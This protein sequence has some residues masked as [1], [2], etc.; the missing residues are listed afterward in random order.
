MHRNVVALGEYIKKSGVPESINTSRDNLE[1]ACNTVD[2]CIKIIEEQVDRYILEK[3]RQIP[4]FIAESLFKKAPDLEANFHRLILSECETFR[5]QQRILNTLNQEFFQNSR[6]LAL[7]PQTVEINVSSIDKIFAQAGQVIKAS[8]VASVI[9]RW[10]SEKIV[11]LAAEGFFC[12]EIIERLIG[13]LVQNSI[14][15][16]QQAEE[17]FFTQRLKYSVQGLLNSI[18]RQLKET[19]S[20]KVA[21]TVYHF[22]EDDIQAGKNGDGRLPA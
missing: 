10:G 6:Q 5:L 13:N 14:K 22:F 1:K 9:G 7:K 15:E 8:R 11:S 18:G 20:F 19:L 4:A 2:G 17:A 3:S 16:A 12:K 21:T